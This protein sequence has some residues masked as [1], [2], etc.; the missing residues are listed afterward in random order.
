MATVTPPP[1]GHSWPRIALSGDELW[2]LAGMAGAGLPTMLSAAGDRAGDAAVTRGLVARGFV[3]VPGPPGPLGVA[4]GVAELLRPLLH[5]DSIAEVE[6][7]SH[8]PLRRVVGGSHDGTALVA[9]EREPNVWVIERRD[10][11]FSQ[12]V[13]QLL[14]EH[15]PPRAEPTGVRLEVP[16]G[17]IREVERL[18]REGRWEEL[19]DALHR[20]GAPTTAVAA[21][22]AAVG[23]SRGR[24]SVLLSRRLPSGAFQTGVLGWLDGAE[25]G[26]WQVTR[27]PGAVDLPG[28]MVVE[29]VGTGAVLASLDRLIGG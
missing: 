5:P 25:R 14:D 21:L 8:P 28:W 26:L 12:Q 4:P 24:G 6:L 20:R 3:M 16:P 27:H 15:L 11:G 1:T 10:G 13:W 19:G 2:L 18:V 7:G 29:S 22:Q 17:A 23:R 9:S